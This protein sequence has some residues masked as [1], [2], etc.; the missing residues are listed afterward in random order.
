[1]I[2]IGKRVIYTYQLTKHG[3]ETVA[4]TG[5]FRGWVTLDDRTYGIVNYRLI[6]KQDIHPIGTIVKLTTGEI[7]NEEYIDF[8]YLMIDMDSRGT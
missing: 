1:M 7:R 5:F 2:E 3:T 8:G 4:G 6:P